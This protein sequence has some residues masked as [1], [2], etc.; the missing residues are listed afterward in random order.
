MRGV[1]Q[2]VLIGFLTAALSLAK[3]VNV[4]ELRQNE[5]RR[6]WVVRVEGR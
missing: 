2:S 4:I 5:Q 3:H 6:L 1:S